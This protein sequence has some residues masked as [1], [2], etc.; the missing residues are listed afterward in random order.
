[1]LSAIA[2]NAADE[3]VSVCPSIA[4]DTVDEESHLDDDESATASRQQRLAPREPV[5]G[6]F[7]SEPNRSS[8]WNN[9]PEVGNFGLHLGNWGLTGTTSNG[10]LNRARPENLKNLAQV[11]V[12]LEAS[13][14]LEDSLKQAAVAGDANAVGLR[15][16]PTQS[17]Y[18]VRG[19]EESAVL[20]AA[21]T[22]VTTGIETLLHEVHEDHAYRV[23]GKQQMARSRI[24]VCKIHFKPNICHLGNDIVVGGVHGH[25]RTMKIEWKQQWDAFWDRLA[26]SV[27]QFEMKFFAGDF[28]MSLTEVPK[29]L[30]SRGILCDCVAWYP[31][32][33]GTGAAVAERTGQRLG[34]DSCGIFYIGGRVQVYTPW[35]YGNIAILTAVADSECEDLDV[36]DGTT[37]PG[38]PWHCYR[39]RAYHERPYEKDLEARLRDLLTPSTT[40]AELDTIPKRHGVEYRPYLRLKQK[41]MRTN[42]WLVQGGLHNGSH[43]PLCVF[44]NNTSGRRSADKVIQRAQRQPVGSCVAVADDDRGWDAWGAETSRPPLLALVP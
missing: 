40:Q 36:Y 8:K 3:S 21:R 9:E 38:Q 2:V 4:G 39:S 30:R 25:Y 17:Y 34:F 31:W 22:D 43:F 23:R 12:V 44:T 7:R 41:D 10:F 11:L 14:Q 16:R 20:I 15:A 5:H 18:V 19:A 32:R 35:N 33:Q 29:Q 27:R 26:R 6:H 1:M 42:E 28:N 13:R 24:L 37:F